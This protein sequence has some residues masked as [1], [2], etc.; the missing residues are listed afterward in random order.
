MVFYVIFSVCNLLQYKTVYDDMQYR[1]M[2]DNVICVRIYT[3]K[4][5]TILVI[6]SY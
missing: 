4:Q 3:R 2:N 1:T 5:H 6:S